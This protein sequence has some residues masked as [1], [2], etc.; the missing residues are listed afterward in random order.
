MRMTPEQFA[1]K[2]QQTPR[3]PGRWALS[4]LAAVVAGTLAA[5]LAAGIF[6]AGAVAVGVDGTKPVDVAGPLVITVAFATVA[7]L[8]WRGIRQRWHRMPPGPETRWGR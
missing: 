6:A 5:L 4:L 7:A 3:Q 2:G 8:T 1:A